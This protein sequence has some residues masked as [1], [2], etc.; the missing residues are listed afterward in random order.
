[1]VKIFALKFYHFGPRKKTFDS[2]HKKM[3]R[4]IEGTFGNLTCAKEARCAKPKFQAKKLE[5][6][7]LDK[8]TMT[9][10]PLIR[11]FNSGCASGPISNVEIYY[12]RSSL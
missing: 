6:R 12:P 3:T 8:V 5:Q 9:I 2:D 11:R 4:N 10:F 7:K 1:M